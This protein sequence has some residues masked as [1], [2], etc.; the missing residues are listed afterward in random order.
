MPKEN[1]CKPW[2]K[3]QKEFA[4]KLE[5]EKRD[6]ERRT[7]AIFAPPC[8]YNV[9]Y[10]YQLNINNKVLN[11]FYED[12]V[13]RKKVGHPPFGDTDRPKW[14][15][16]L[17]KI[18]CKNFMKYDRRCASEFPASLPKEGHITFGLADWKREGFELFINNK[19]D[20]AAALGEFAEKE[21]EIEYGKFRI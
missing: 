17:W 15:Q 16:C 8:P 1:Y 18:L 9:K 12:T 3:A 10:H 20:V 19:L 13:R 7:L 5:K 6:R 11:I 4:E 2:E 14:E 21:D